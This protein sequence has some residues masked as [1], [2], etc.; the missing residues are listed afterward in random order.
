MELDQK[1]NLLNC[2]KS[3]QRKK[4]HNNTTGKGTRA[5]D[6]ELKRPRKQEEQS[7]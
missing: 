1:L 3:K 5:T 2:K 6:K 7:L 4:R